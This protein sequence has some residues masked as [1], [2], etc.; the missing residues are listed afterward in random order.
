MAIAEIRY[1]CNERVVEECFAR[2]LWCAELLVCV[3]NQLMICADV[4]K[5][6]MTTLQTGGFGPAPE[7]GAP[8]APFRFVD[9]VKPLS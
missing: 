8:L 4:E 3:M 2:F 7:I 1:G 9:R 6:E 5:G